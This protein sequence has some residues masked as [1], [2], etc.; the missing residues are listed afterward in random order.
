MAAMRE[1]LIICAIGRDRPG[2][3]DRLSGEIFRRG[4]N[5]EDSRMAILG[6]DFALVA[7]VAG[8]PDRLAEVQRGAEGIC[9]ELELTAQFRLTR[10]GPGGPEIGERIP[11]KLTAVSLDQPGIVH[12]IA[13]LLAAQGVNVANLETRLTHAPITGA[14]MFSLEL[15]AQVPA[16]TPMARLRQALRELADAENIDLELRAIP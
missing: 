9:R 14:P 8:P 2:I 11:Y 15:E 12:K 6:G 5:L 16:A 3:V 10:I 1:G 13:H 7:L 4:C